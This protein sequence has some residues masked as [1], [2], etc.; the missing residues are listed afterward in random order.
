MEFPENTDMMPSMLP[1]A[2]GGFRFFRTRVL[3]PAQPK[4]GEK[5]VRGYSKITKVIMSVLMA[6]FA[7]MCLEIFPGGISQ[8]HGHAQV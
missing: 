3:A 7:F 8:R 2:V 5:M 4:K 6:F 1:A